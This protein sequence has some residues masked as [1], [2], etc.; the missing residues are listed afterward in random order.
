MHIELVL[1]LLRRRLSYAKIVILSATL[2]T[3]LRFLTYIINIV[4]LIF[5]NHKMYNKNRNGG[6]VYVEILL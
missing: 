6:I 4:F 3:S 2:I 1:K 5:R